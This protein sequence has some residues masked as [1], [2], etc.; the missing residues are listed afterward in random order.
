M[1]NHVTFETSLFN[2]TEVKD[3][4]INP[5]CFGDDTAAWLSKRLSEQGYSVI[6]EPIQEDWGWEIE[7]KHKANG[8]WFNIGLLEDE[9]AWLV[10]V[11]P[12][13]K[14]FRKVPTSAVIE[15]SVALDKVLK[16]EPEIRK[17]R[18]YDDADFTSGKLDLWEKSPTGAG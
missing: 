10:W 7:V 6:D 16:A 18:W 15:M 1:H 14:L 2:M 11:E 4:F 3:Y 9:R 8:F 5:C 17:I 12:Q 13:N